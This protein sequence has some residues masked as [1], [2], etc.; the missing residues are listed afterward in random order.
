M[1]LKIS[2]LITLCLAATACWH[3]T[4]LMKMETELTRYGETMRWGLYQ[5]AA[6]F[7]SPDKR[8]PFNSEQLKNIH[9]TS[10]S[11]TYTQETSPTS[12]I[13]KQTV[14]IHY[15]DE[16]TGVERSV[17]DNQTWRYDNEKDQWFLESGLPKFR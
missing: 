3:S 8:T 1:R 5:Q 7:R 6:D 2:V 16:Q 15:Y 12:T 10:Y 17:T 11:P 9:V 13:F 14:E 4:H